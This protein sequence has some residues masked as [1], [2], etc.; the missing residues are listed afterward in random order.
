MKRNNTQRR[1]PAEDGSYLSIEHGWALECD[2]TSAKHSNLFVRSAITKL[3]EILEAPPEDEHHRV[4]RSITAARFAFEITDDIGKYLA[5]L[6]ATIDSIGN[7]DK[8]KVK[9]AA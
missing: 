6:L 8:Q 5:R 3:L 2:A 9:R 4:Q 7:P 1:R